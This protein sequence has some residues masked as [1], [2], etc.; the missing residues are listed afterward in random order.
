MESCEKK[1]TWQWT[2]FRASLYGDLG[3]ELRLPG[4][5]LCLF[6]YGGPFMTWSKRY[7]Y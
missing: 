2:V 7:S 1:P 6:C 5:Q 3:H 4:K